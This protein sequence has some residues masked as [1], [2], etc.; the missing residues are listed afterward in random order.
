M[1]KLQQLKKI[2]C[3]THIV[4][5]DIKNEYFA[6]TDGFAVVMQFLPAFVEHGYAL[7]SS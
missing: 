2:D 1:S 5:E 3:H 6:E 7:S 4:T